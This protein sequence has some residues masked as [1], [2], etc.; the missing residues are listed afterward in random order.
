[1][2]VI[3]LLQNN[4]KENEEEVGKTTNANFWRVL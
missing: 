4:E 1:M 3:R 2:F